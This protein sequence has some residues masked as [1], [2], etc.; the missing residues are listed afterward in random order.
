MAEARQIVAA[1]RIDDGNR[2]RQHFV[3]LM[4]IDD[5]D[6]EA[7][8]LGLGQRLDTGGAAIDADQKRR[9]ALGERA[10]RFDIRAIAFEQP[11]GNVDDRID[12]AMAQIARQQRRRGRAVDVVIAEDGD[13]LS[14]RAT[15]S[16]MRVAASSIAVS[17]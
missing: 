1:V 4:V 14:P 5:D 11:V 16:A 2:R 12:A 15:A 7:E 13:V 10:H 9:A 3:G 8:L 17:T 6:I